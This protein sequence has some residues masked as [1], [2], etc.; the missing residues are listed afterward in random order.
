MNRK[1]VKLP[2]M[3]LIIFL[4]MGIVFPQMHQSLA[5]NIFNPSIS[6]NSA[7]GKWDIK[8]I[9]ID[10]TE[11][12]SITWHGPAGALPAYIDEELVFDGM[13]NIASLTFLPDHIY[14]ITFSFKDSEGTPVQFTNKYGELTEQETLFF[15][16]KITFQGTSFNDAAVLGGLEDANPDLIQSG[17]QTIRVISGNNP[18]VTLRWKVPTIWEPMAGGVLHITNKNVNLDRLESGG[19]SHVDLD[20]GYF[21]IKM[22]VTDIV[23]ERIFTTTVQEGTGV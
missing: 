3:L 16:S 21:H 1:S 4:L 15:L 19:T 14:D 12:Y 17:G 6:Y 13:Y 2:A 11:T 7:T 18:K 10:G 8:W 5:N 23:T 9:P 20:Y 22:K